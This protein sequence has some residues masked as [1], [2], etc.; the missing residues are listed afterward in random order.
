MILGLRHRDKNGGFVLLSRIELS[1][2]D[3]D[4]INML[5]M[6]F[7]R[8]LQD[9]KADDSIIKNEADI[10]TWMISDIPCS[11]KKLNLD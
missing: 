10:E 7:T 5:T 2:W 11:E 1:I 4:N 6:K 3:Q 8:S 9:I